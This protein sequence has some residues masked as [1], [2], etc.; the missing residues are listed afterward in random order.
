MA[1]ALG[2]LYAPRPAHSGRSGW[3]N[4][5]TWESQPIQTPCQINGYTHYRFVSQAPDSNPLGLKDRSVQ[6]FSSSERRAGSR[7]LVPK[8][9]RKA[10]TLKSPPIAYF[11]EFL[12]RAVLT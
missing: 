7:S 1:D 3:S 5:T 12:R 11:Y 6:Q 9:P 4:R 8:I 10:K 2:C